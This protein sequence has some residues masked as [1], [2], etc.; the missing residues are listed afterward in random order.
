MIYIESLEELVRDLEY[1][2]GV[3]RKA[4]RRIFKFLREKSDLLYDQNPWAYRKIF[5][6]YANEIRDHQLV[7]ICK[8]L[9]ERPSGRKSRG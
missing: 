6:G 5:N 7:G 3:R 9:L 2:I 8:R 4:R 1:T